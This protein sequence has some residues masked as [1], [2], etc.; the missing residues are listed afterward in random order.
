[1]KIH[2]KLL[3][4]G[5]ILNWNIDF[6][7]VGWQRD[8]LTIFSFKKNPCFWWGTPHS[9]LNLLRLERH[10]VHCLQ[11]LKV[12]YKGSQML[13][14]FP[15]DRKL[16][17]QFTWLLMTDCKEGIILMC[18][19]MQDAALGSLF[20]CV[21]LD[22]KLIFKLFSEFGQFFGLGFFFFFGSFVVVFCFFFLILLA[23]G[24]SSETQSQQTCE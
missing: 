20:T 24:P 13:V 7:R 22:W 10:T 15:S 5:N 9:R 11:F 8:P 2:T 6:P 4:P 19:C 12:T 14:S 18:I 21:F 16:S 1:M 17:H 23:P 3:Y